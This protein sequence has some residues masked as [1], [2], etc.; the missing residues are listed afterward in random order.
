MQ[1]RPIW[2][3]LIALLYRQSYA[4][5]FANFVIPLPVAYVFRNEVPEPALIGW[6]GAMYLLTGARIVLAKL[7]F[8]HEAAEDALRWAW[9]AT[10]FSW[11]SAALWGAIGWVGFIPGDPN[12]AAFTCIVLTGLACGAVPSLSAFPP[13]YAGT[14]VFMLLPMAIRCVLGEGEIFRIYLLFILCLVAVNLYYSRQTFRMLSETVRL[15]S[16]NLALIGDLEQQRDRAQ[17]ADRSKSRFLAAASH[18]LRQPVHAMSLFVEALSVMAQRGD[19]LAAEARNIAGRLRAVIG[20]FGGV[21]NGLLDIS[22]LDAGVVKMQKEPVSLAHLLDE[23]KGEFADIARERGLDWRVVGSTGWVDTDPALLR[24]ILGNLLTNAFRYT[25]TGKVLLGVRCR[26]GQFEI[27]VLDTGAGIPAGQT[28]AIFDEFV[29][30]PNAEKQGLG[31]G[32]SIVRRTA[33]LLGHHLHLRSK[34]GRGSVFSILIAAAVP[35]V[36]K[37]DIAQDM[38]AAPLNIAVI[39][40]EQDALDGLVNLLE[41]WGHHVWAGISAEQ[42]IATMGGGTPDLL[43][44]DYRLGDGI[45]GIAAAEAVWRHLGRTIPIIIVT[46]DTAPDRLRETTASGHKLLHKPVDPDALKQAIKASSR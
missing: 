9:R 42:L 17:A 23:L 27:A 10:A 20:N 44:T 38:G 1:E 28:E 4:I 24:R 3:A 22:R 21:L 15:R 16:E 13:A 14:A 26:K 40:D 33:D 6:I 43:V 19:V 29:Q 35:G 45:T 31:L 2:E 34:E 39:D 36:V 32:L 7:Y 41:V 37:Q 18:D 25:K 5:L 46:G 12:L 30:L 11:A 8:S